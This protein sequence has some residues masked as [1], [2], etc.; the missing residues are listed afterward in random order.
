MNRSAVAFAASCGVLAVAGLIDAA[1]AGTGIPVTV[2]FQ[3][4]I[5]SPG[6][7]QIGSDGN[8][9]YVDG[10]AIEARLDASG[11]LNLD[12][13]LHDL[14]GSRTLFV[15]F[16]DAKTVCTT[17]GA[18]LVPFTNPTLRDAYMSTSSVTVNGTLV[19]GLLQMP[20]PSVGRTN[21]N[22]NIGGWFVRFN[23]TYYPGS[24]PVTVTRVDEHNWTIE[25]ASPSTGTDWAGLIR[26]S[27]NGRETN[28]GEYYL[29]TQIMVYC[30]SC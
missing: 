26:L 20:V 29:P 3:S 16:Q 1:G 10:G 9:A 8:G 14:A 22:V 15:A 12:T 6:S 17:C 2:T 21:L 25:A 23:P 27:K 30:P 28:V 7:D 5:Q 4:S 18:P 11:N 13:A 19:G 24:T